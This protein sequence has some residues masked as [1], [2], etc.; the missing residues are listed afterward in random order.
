MFTA[1]VAVGLHC[2]RTAVLMTQPAGNGRNVHARFDAAR[3]KQLPQVVMNDAMGA[4]FLSCPIERLLTFADLEHFGIRWFV[5][6]AHSAVVQ[7]ASEHLESWESGASLPRP[8]FPS[9]RHRAPQPRLHQNP[10][11][12]I[13]ARSLRPCA[14]RY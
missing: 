7:T 9:P 1:K 8:L 11:R 12:A 5:G 3:R 13:P 6:R 2:Q 4:D 14:F 10:D